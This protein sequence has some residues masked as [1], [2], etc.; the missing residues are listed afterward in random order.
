MRNG[1]YYVEWDCGADLSADTI[2]A[3]TDWTATRAGPV[4]RK[5]MKAKNGFT[6][7]EM[8]VVIAILGILMAMMIPAAGMIIKR[9][10]VSTAKSD[11]GIS[12][13][14]MVKYLAEYNRWPGYV[15]SQDPNYTDADWV[16]VMTPSPGDPSSPFNLKRIKFFE[17]SSGSLG[18]GDT[19]HAGAF[20]DPWGNPFQYTVDFNRQGQ[21]GNPEATGVIRA[22]AIAWSAGPD[23]DYDTWTDNVKSWE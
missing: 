3:Q 7:I 20:V 23:G 4:R 12:T 13:T 18:A 19:A 17:P 22:Q 10:K 11:A 1:G 8:L 14:A 5:T 15:S 21:V 6:L 2:E 16:R 9:A